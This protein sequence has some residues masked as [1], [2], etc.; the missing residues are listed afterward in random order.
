MK[1]IAV[2]NLQGERYPFEIQS[3]QVDWVNCETT[4]VQQVQSLS[5]EYNGH[6]LLIGNSFGGLS[7]WVFATEQCPAELKGV[8]LINVLPNLH[9]VPI[10]IRLGVSVLHRLPSRLSQPLYNLYRRFISKSPVEVKEVLS[11]V[12][13]FQESFPEPYFPV[14]TLVVS[15]NR[16]FNNLWKQISVGQDLL[17]VQELGDLSIQVSKWLQS[18]HEV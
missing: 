9:A 8:V 14:P 4:L 18:L 1:I 16:H 7:A 6:E 15:T 17:T 11:R 10:R 2:P 3:A 5:Q 13:S 12:R